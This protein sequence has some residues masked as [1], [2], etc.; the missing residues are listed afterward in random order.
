MLT[1]FQIQHSEN[2]KLFLK[3]ISNSVVFCTLG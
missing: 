3:N 1:I 2:F